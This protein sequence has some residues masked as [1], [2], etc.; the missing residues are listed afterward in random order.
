MPHNIAPDLVSLARP[1]LSLKLDP[2]NA[3]KHP[4]S[5][6]KAIQA[7]LRRFGQVKPVVGLE[8]GTIIAGNGTLRAAAAEGWD[9]LA[10][11]AFKDEASARAYAIADNRTAEL[12]EWDDPALAEALG[13]LQAQGEDFA[14]IGFT[15]EDALTAMSKV[16]SSITV[17]GAEPD[18]PKGAD[19]RPR[20]PTEDMR[21]SHVR[22]VQLFLNA[23]TQPVFLENVQKLSKRFGTDN[24]TDTVARAVAELA[25]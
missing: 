2:K 3:R 19:D 21:A 6:I 16:A 8:D 15:M 9:M 22:M 12:S 14:N 5:S 18:K 1:I 7:S 24:V 4:D 10:V 23:E 25:K 20:G 11:V 13:A 17:D